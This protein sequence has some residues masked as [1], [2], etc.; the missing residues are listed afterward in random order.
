M[1]MSFFSS[2]RKKLTNIV[3]TSAVLSLFSSSSMELSE[4]KESVRFLD[5]TIGNN[6][7]CPMKNMK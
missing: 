2:T 1:E 4:E 5:C 7:F 6:S 3:M